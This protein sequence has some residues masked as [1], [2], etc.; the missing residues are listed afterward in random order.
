MTVDDTQ[1]KTVL[2]VE[3][4]DDED[5]PREFWLSIGKSIMW[6]VL[7]FSLWFGVAYMYYN[8]VQICTLGDHEV[9]PFWDLPSGNY[10]CLSCG[11]MSP[12]DIDLA[13]E[14]CLNA[15][16]M[17]GNDVGKITVVKDW[18][19]QKPVDMSVAIQT[20]RFEP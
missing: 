15:T 2:P 16:F 20:G 12:D 1:E 13:A 14:Q 8:H 10:T 11:V 7:W 4:D 9:I 18:P 6:G 3:E 17:F 19:F 5:S